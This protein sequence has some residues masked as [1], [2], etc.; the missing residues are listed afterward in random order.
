V[1]GV[2]VDKAREIQLLLLIGVAG[3]PL[4]EVGE[5][6]AWRDACRCAAATHVRLAAAAPSLAERARLL[7]YDE[8]YYRRWRDRAEALVIAA[9]A[10][11]GDG[12]RRVLR[13]Y[14]EAVP[15]LLEMPTAFIHG[16]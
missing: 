5:L 11:A 6:E 2:S 13:A 7:R 1:D 15:K 8:T 12:M 3:V 4:W 9:G 14:E 10:G 16:E